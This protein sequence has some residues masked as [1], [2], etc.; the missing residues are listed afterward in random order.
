MLNKS[1]F[2]KIPEK[3]ISTCSKLT[4]ESCLL[5]CTKVNAKWIKD[6]SARPET[7]NLLEK[8]IGETLQ[9]TGIGKDFLNRILMAQGIR[10]RIDMELP[11]I[12]KL[13]TSRKAVVRAKRQPSG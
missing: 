5:L 2:G 7:L 4:L 6:L 8:N 12:K 10:A 11:P 9:Y 3:L 13:W 1:F